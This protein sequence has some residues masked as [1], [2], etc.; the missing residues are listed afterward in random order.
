MKGL[1]DFL[2][3]EEGKHLA[4]FLQ[5]RDSLPEETNSEEYGVKKHAFMDA[6]NDERLYAKMDAREFVQLSIDNWNVFRVA[7]GFEK[8]SILYFTEFL[9]H[10]SESNREIV[11]GLIDEEKGHIRK[12]VDLMELIGE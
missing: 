9:P 5:I 11:R 4:T 6:I 2:A 1:F 7:I 10:L 3:E 8:D 12:L